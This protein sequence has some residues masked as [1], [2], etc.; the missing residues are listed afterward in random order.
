MNIEN[1]KRIMKSNLWKKIRNNKNY[2]NY[3]IL[4]TKSK[5]NQRTSGQFFVLL[6]FF[7]YQISEDTLKG[8]W[9]EGA[10]MSIGEGLDGYVSDGFYGTIKMLRFS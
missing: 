3:M 6:V 10:I 9:K 8:Y 1:I 5:E 2:R 4:D 7:N